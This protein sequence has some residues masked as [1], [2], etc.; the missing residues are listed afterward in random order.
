MA[1][2]V[3]E[4]NIK[5]LE[6]AAYTLSNLA[7]KEGYYTN[8]EVNE[9]EYKICKTHL[10]DLKKSMLQE[11]LMSTHFPLVKFIIE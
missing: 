10:K 4:K 11:F 5:S 7:I 8:V 3:I 2:V 6:L 1:H 9:N